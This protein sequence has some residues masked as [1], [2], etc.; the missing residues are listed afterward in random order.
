MII[1]PRLALQLGLI[2]N[3]SERDSKNPEGAG[4]DLRVGEVFVLEGEGGF[5]GIDTR[6]TPD[7]RLVAKFGEDKEFTLNPGDYVLVR[8]IEE[9]ELPGGPIDIPGVG[10]ACVMADVR[11]RST[12][13]RSG[14]L[15]LATKTDPGYYGKLT[16]GMANLG[17]LPFTF[18]LGAR[19]ANI[20]FFTVTEGCESYRGQ[21]KGGRVVVPK[22]EKQV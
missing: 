5:I 7:A 21:W 15:L 18:E 14:V 19:I 16:F 20:V 11:T 22:E 12:L 17:P 4:F 10:K 8:T 3:L 1:A 6:K 13:F 9:V 2:K